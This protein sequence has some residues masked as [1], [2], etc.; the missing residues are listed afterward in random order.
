MGGSGTTWGQCSCGIGGRHPV[1]GAG[2]SQERNDASEGR[3]AVRL[4]HGEPYDY[5]LWDDDEA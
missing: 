5:D 4:A 1:H 2:A 3:D